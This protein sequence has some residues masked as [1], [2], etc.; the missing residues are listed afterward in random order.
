[1]TNTTPICDAL[2]PFKESFRTLPPMPEDRVYRL[3]DADIDGTLPVEY[4]KAVALP[5]VRSAVMGAVKAKDIGGSVLIAG[6]PGTGKTWQLY[7]LLR[8]QRLRRAADLINVGER[9]RH[10]YTE[11]RRWKIE[12]E[13]AWAKRRVADVIA[14]DILVIISESSDIRSARYDREKLD[15]WCQDER[16][17]AVDEVGCVKPSDWVLEAVYEI[18]TQRRKEG[19]TTIWTTNLTPDELRQSFG[20]AIASRMLGDSVIAFDGKDRRLA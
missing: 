15:A 20:A 5:A 2:E 9:V 8:G 18:A 3:T 11:S 10:E 17:L 13:S 12:L 14:R 7:G 16:I 4:R 6:P 1:M 19:R